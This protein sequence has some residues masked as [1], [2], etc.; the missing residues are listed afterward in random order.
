[1]NG[2][3]S[4]LAR[5]F[6]VDG[7]QCGG[8]NAQTAPRFEQAGRPEARASAQQARRALA[9]NSRPSQG[10]TSVG[11]QRERQV[12]GDGRTAGVGGNERNRWNCWESDGTR[13]Q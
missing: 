5:T 10:F 4:G 2:A 13:D 8:A 1:M 7:T 3:C 9:V 11:A 12:R 6:A